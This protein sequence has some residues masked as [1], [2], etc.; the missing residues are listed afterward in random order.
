MDITYLK[1]ELDLK[2]TNYKYI[3]DFI[4]HFT[5]FYYGFLISDKSAETKLKYIK[6]FIQINKKPVIFQCDNGKEFINNTV[7]EYLKKENI[8]W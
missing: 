6:L 4:D 3:I 2:K 5:K 8:K 1:S 7:K